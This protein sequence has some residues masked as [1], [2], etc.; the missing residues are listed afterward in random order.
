M[1]LKC[2]QEPLAKIQ[3][4]TE[5]KLKELSSMTGSSDMNEQFMIVATRGL[6]SALKRRRC[7]ILMNRL[8]RVAQSLAGSYRCIGRHKHFFL[9]RPRLWHFV[10]AVQQPWL[11]TFQSRMLNVWSANEYIIA[12]FHLFHN[13]VGW[14]F[15]YLSLRTWIVDEPGGIEV[16]WRQSLQFSVKHDV[17]RSWLHAYMRLYECLLRGEYG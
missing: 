15:S 16:H 2:Q 12:S 3:E 4:A 10:F 17:R 9:S 8:V 13:E 1:I 14:K 11:C 5:N 6:L 7:T